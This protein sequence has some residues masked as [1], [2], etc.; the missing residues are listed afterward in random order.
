MSTVTRPALFVIL[1]AV[2]AA[3]F[4]QT[5]SSSRIV[6]GSRV[7]IAPMDG[8]ETYF[9]AAVREKKVPIALTLDKDSAQYFIVSTETEWRGFV[10]GSAAS[11]S[12]SNGTGSYNSGAGASSTRGLEASIMLID[13]K[14]KDVVWAYEVHKNSHGALILGTL[15]ARGKQSVAEACAKHLKEFIEKD[16]S[17][18]DKRASASVVITPIAHDPNEGRG[19]AVA[20]A[21][22]TVPSPQPSP[23]ATMSTVSVGSSPAGADIL[24]DDE[25]TGNTPSTINVPAGKHT[26][27]VRKP[28]F[29]DWIRSM[30]FYGGSITLSAELSR[31]TPDGQG[32]STKAPTSA[33][34]VPLP[35][36]D[37]GPAPEHP[38]VPWIGVSAQSSADGA[39]LTAVVAGG[40]GASAGLQPGDEILALDGRLLKGKDFQ[41]AVAALKP[42]TQ[43]SIKYARGSSAHEVWVT[44]GSQ[45]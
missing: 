43:V 44:V 24:V 1:V 20:S 41:A 12:W 32:S 14:T 10:Y 6:P 15:A 27:T 7:V 34:A 40:P 5:P 38:V 35:L 36:T 16:Q 3:A 23:S 45:N 28:G 39:T 26:V 21:P 8:F 11:A 30:N 17:G 22:A 37:P 31:P 18:S 13:G 33:A 9:A 42:G 19:A 2:V 29:Q 25:F 4:G